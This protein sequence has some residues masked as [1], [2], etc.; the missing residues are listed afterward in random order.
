[1][2]KSLQHD[3]SLH[4]VVALSAN[5]RPALAACAAGCSQLDKVRVGG[6]QPRTCFSSR[7]CWSG[8]VTRICHAEKASHSR[9]RRVRPT[10]LSM[11]RCFAAA[12]SLQTSSMLIV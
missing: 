2:S 9:R 3:I 6:L 11:R 5:S 10:A 12:S 7:E 8:S 1:M 4:P